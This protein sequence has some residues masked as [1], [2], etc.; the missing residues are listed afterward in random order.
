M[1]GTMEPEQIQY[2][3]L[4]ERGVLSFQVQCYGAKHPITLVGSDIAAKLKELQ[5]GRRI[6]AT[7]YHNGMK[8]DIWKHPRKQYRLEYQPTGAH[9]ASAFSCCIT[10]PEKE[11]EKLFQ[12]FDCIA[13]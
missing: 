11:M 2:V 6:C 4:E 10:I 8:L 5:R 12:V 7:F 1:G 3:M 9:S 13:E